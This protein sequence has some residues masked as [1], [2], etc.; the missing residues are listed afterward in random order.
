MSKFSL[1]CAHFRYH[2]QN[3]LE[4]HQHVIADIDTGN[5]R[6]IFVYDVH[7]LTRHF[8]AQYIQKTLSSVN[9]TLNNIDKQ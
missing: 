7:L 4:L 6:I 8:D 3:G 5:T 2:P 1:S 9:D